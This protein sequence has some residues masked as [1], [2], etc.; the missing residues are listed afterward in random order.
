MRGL[1][2]GQTDDHGQTIK[3]REALK[4]SHKLFL[5][6]VWQRVDIVDLASDANIIV[7]SGAW[8]SYEGNKIG[9]GRENTKQYLKDNP[10]LLEEINIK[11]RTHY[12][13]DG[14]SK[15]DAGQIDSGEN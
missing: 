7:K 4:D 8:Y 15:D 10:D 12:G 1:S 6:S 14:A 5:P 3:V 9:Q 11:V 2:F 13:L